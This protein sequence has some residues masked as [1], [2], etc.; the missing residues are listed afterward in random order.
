MTAE[1]GTP[2]S[3]VTPESGL[4]GDCVH[5]RVITSRRGSTFLLCGLSSSDPRFPRYPRLPVVACIG[6]APGSVGGAA[7]IS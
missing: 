2:V 4:C 3:G 5:A 1:G 7:R 6:W